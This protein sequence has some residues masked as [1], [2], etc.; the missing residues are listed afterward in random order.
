MRHLMQKLYLDASFV[1]EMLIETP[2]VLRVAETFV[3][4]MEVEQQN[5]LEAISVD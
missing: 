1:F 2:L 3:A 4:V 5:N